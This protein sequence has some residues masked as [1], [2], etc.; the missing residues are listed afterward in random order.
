[1]GTFQPTSFSVSSGKLMDEDIPINISTQNQ[2]R[3][4]YRDGSY[5]TY[6][7]PQA[8][9]YH[10]VASIVQYDN[11]GVLANVDNNSF[12]AYW[13]FGTNDT[14]TPIYSIM[15]QRQDNTLSLSQINNTYEGLVL[16]DLPFQEMKVL[17]RVILRRSGTS[18][19]I[20]DVLDLRSVSNLPSGTYVATNHAQLSGL[21]TSGHPAAVIEENINRRF[22][23]D[24]EKTYW[25]AKASTDLATTSTNGLMSST[26][27]T[28]LDGVEIG[29][30]N[31]IHPT[32]SA[33][34]SDNSNGTV[35]QDISINTL[36]HVT[37]VGTA[38]LDSRYYTE[39]ETNTLLNSKANLS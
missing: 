36:G 3:V 28:K 39:T 37:S 2:C 5:Y 31:Y 27:K 11:I 20:S 22:V 12:V 21:N 16:L 18:V 35:I 13:I 23:S 25:N 17:Y 10:S 34:T 30:N 15:G 33:I 7:A 26:D 4:L 32:Q 24:I 6:T 19:T 9:F 8:N 38:N 29:A 1:M 14:S